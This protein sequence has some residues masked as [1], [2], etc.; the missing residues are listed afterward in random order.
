MELFTDEGEFVVLELFEGFFD[1][2][3]GDD[4]GGVD[5]GERSRAK[6]SETINTSLSALA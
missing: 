4:A 3:V 1:G 2:G 6:G 5:P